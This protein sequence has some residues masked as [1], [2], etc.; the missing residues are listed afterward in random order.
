MYL[1]NQFS[2]MTGL[3]KKALRYYDEQEILTP[4]VRDAEN[5][6]W[7]YDEEDLCRAKMIVLLRKLHTDTI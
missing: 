5:Q 1:I 4:S 3:T 7:Q 6:Y 2:K